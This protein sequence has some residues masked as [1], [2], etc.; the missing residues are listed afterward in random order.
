MRNNNQQGNPNFHQQITLI[1]IL[2]DVLNDK[3]GLLYESKNHLRC[4]LRQ[5]NLQKNFYNQI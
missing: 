2:D 1:N 4:N 3:N 5:L